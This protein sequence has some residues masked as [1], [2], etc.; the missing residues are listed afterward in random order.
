MTIII[1]NKSIIKRKEMC[2]R[3]SKVKYIDIY[4]EVIIEMNTVT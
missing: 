3:R 2:T 1:D 4:I